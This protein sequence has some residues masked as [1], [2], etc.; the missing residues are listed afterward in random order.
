M[1][2]EKITVRTVVN[3]DKQK[4]WNYYIKPEHIINW[5]FAR[6]DW[7]CL[8]ASNDLKVE[9]RYFERMETKDGSWGFDFDAVYTE[10]QHGKYFIYEFGGRFATVEFKETNGQTEVIISFDPE[11]EYPIE[12]QRNVRQAIPDNFRKYVEEN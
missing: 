4:V 6:N 7:H 8:R 1:Q 9:G 12:T 11:N 3:A 10:I 5:N 2:Q